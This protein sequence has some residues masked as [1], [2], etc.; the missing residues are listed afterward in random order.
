MLFEGT[1]NFRTLHEVH[2][3]T[4]IVPLP[5]QK[6]SRQHKLKIMKTDLPQK[7]CRPRKSVYML[8]VG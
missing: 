4:M 6:F 1:Q 5:S 2:K 3:F 8:G 7:A